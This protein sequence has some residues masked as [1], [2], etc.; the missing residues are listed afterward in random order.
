MVDDGDTYWSQPVGTGVVDE[1]V[2]L[3]VELE[4]LAKICQP[5]S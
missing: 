1:D 3:S 4:C 5:S 2:D